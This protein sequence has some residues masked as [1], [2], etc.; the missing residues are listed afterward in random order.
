M[1]IYVAHSGKFDFHK[2]LYK[3]LEESSLSKDHIFFFPEKDQNKIINTNKILENEIDLL[4]AE[5][6]FPATG[7][8]IE[9]GRAE[10]YNV[11]ILCV[12]K[13][14]H[15]FSQSVKFATNNFLEYEND[16][17]LIDKISKF[18]SSLY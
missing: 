10:A 2:E 12:Y 9:I 17:D 14:G 18:I 5:V 7:L 11:P 8:G 1:R 3:P 4:I 15:E 16:A 6:S 13:K